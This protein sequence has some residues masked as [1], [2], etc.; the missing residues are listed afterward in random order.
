MVLDEERDLP[1]CLTSVAFCDEIVVVDSG[2]TDRTKEIAAAAGARVVEQ[3]WLG[4]AAQRN[5]ALDHARGDWVLEIDA[6]ERVTPALRAELEAFL[7]AEPPGIDVGGI[8]RREVLAGH[9]LGPAA[10]YPNYCHRLLRRGTL[11]HDERRTV[12][13]GLVP[14]GP[15]HPFVGELTHLY[16]PTWGVAIADARRYARLEAE[17]ISAPR[18][19]SRILAGAL[20]RPAAKLLYRATLDGGWRDGPTGVA[21]IALDCVADGSVWVRYALQG[22][23]GNGASGVAATEHFG[24]HRFPRG[25]PHVAAVA[26]GA[27]PTRRAAAWARSAAAEGLDVAILSPGEAPEPVIRH[28]RLATPGPL[29]VVRALD[30]EEQLRTLDAVVAFGPRARRSLVLAPGTLKGSVPPP[31]EGIVPAELTRLVHAAREERAA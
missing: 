29:S 30:A 18:T 3:P 2:S 21:K 28:R 11:R 7:G 5:V 26:V 14:E 8:P 16:A 9:P 19:A 22:P 12:H 31:E 23:T 15:V 17:Q 27:G 1:D 24:S 10:K 6:D 13:E 20:A 25:N 4:F